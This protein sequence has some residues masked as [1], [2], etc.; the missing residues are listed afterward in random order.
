MKVYKVLN[1][2]TGEYTDAETLLAC[3]NLVS[4]TAYDFYMTHTHGNPFTVVTVDED[5]GAEIWTGVNGETIL[6]PAE[7]Q[8]AI[9][10]QLTQTL[11]ITMLGG[12]DVS[13]R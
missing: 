5:T 9:N 10:Q 3:L 6:S 13:T 4:K 11:P 7:I 1:P 8:E 12:A 2:Q